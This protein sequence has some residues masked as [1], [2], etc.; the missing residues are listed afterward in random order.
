MDAVQI[1]AATVRNIE[2]LLERKGWSRGE[3]SRRTG[4][5]R[6]HVSRL[7]SGSRATSLDT[8]AKVAAALEVSPDKLLG[9]PLIPLFSDPAQCGRPPEWAEKAPPPDDWLNLST[10]FGPPDE[11][12]LVIARGDSMTGAGI[13]EGDHLVIRRR[14]AGEIGQRVLALAGG[15]ATVKELAK[16]DRKLVLRSCADGHPDIPVSQDTV[17]LGQV[18]GVIKR[19]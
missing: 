10:F 16:R 12:F 13:A 5:E 17:V 3:L 8:V 14:D 2:R 19:T 7:M 9:P 15:A 11:L 6:T 18:V 1:T 4:I